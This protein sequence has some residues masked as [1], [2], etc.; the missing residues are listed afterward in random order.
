VSTSDLAN[1]RAPLDPVE[2]DHCTLVHRHLRSLVA[3]AAVVVA[4]VV[5]C[6]AAELERTLAAGGN[7]VPTSKRW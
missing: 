6:V 5:A 1:Y 3:A 4:V 7:G 2:F